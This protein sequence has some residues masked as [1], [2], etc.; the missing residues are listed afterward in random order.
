M[1]DGLCSLFKVRSPFIVTACWDTS[2]GHFSVF[3][4]SEN[5]RAAADPA[6]RHGGGVQLGHQLGQFSADQGEV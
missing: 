2:L 5:C 1:F 3:P 4:L 6:G